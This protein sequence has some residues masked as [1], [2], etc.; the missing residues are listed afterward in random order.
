MSTTDTSRVTSGATTRV[1]TT[2]QVPRKKRWVLWGTAMA[3]VVGAVCGN[4]VLIDQIAD[5][6]PVL[7]LARDVP[8]GQPISGAD[9]TPVELPSEVAEFAT[10]QTR[11]GEV[12][13]KTA[14]HTLRAGHLLAY[15]DVT[16]QAIPGPGQ[17]VVGV[18]LEPGRFPARGL[19]PNDPVTVH[20]VPDEDSSTSSGPTGQVEAAEAFTARVVRASPPDADGAITTDLLIPSTTAPDA[21]EAA[22]GGAVISLLGP[23]HP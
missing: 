22:A 14:G 3:L 10:P 7:V 17:T 1:P 6:T 2:P 18:R 11:R 8:W 16:A 21:V 23:G 20:P 12:V 4:V 13:G 9:L 19:V 5:R 15:S